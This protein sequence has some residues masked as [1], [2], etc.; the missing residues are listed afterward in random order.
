M[1]PHALIEAQEL[2]E[3]LLKGLTAYAGR[4]FGQSLDALVFAAL[5]LGI[6]SNALCARLNELRRQG[7][8]P[9][10]RSTSSVALKESRSRAARAVRAHIQQY[11]NA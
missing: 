8:I 9:S 7:L 1:D 2:A 4:G 10:F 6:E 3:A 5:Q 11:L